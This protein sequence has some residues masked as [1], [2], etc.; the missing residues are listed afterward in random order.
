MF[1]VKQSRH[2]DRVLN[3]VADHFRVSVEELL[4][5]DTHRRIA[6]PRQVAMWLLR[7]REASLPEIARVLQRRDHTTVLHG[8]RRIEALRTANDYFRE[9]TDGLRSAMD[10]LS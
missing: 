2:V 4:S 8:V 1:D 5:S 10:A 3:L 9:N 6:R 7:R